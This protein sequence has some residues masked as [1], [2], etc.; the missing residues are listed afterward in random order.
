MH[1]KAALWTEIPERMQTFDIVI[2][3]SKTI[4]CRLPHTGHDTH[5]DGDIRTISDFHTNLAIRRGHR[6]HDVGHHVH[7]TA[8]HSTSKKRSHLGFG[9]SRGHPVVVWSG[10]LALP[11]THIGEMLGPCHV[12]GIAPVQIAAWVLLLIKLYQRACFKHSVDHMLVLGLGAIAPVDIFGMR[13][14]GAFLNPL[15]NGG[16]HKRS[17]L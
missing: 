6:P 9:F 4:E 11:R 8:P 7:R 10:I 5:T 1:D 17:S 12:C 2:R 16:W 15:L 13:E 14:L 3:R